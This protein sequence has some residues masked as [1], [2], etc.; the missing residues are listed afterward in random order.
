[1]SIFVDVDWLSVVI[2]PAPTL[3]IM[4]FSRQT[5]TKNVYKRVALLFD[6]TN[7]CLGFNV[8]QQR[9]VLSDNVNVI[10]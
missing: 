9:S 10:C 8:K 4:H 2:Y 7:K 6:F 1:M 3:P 5:A